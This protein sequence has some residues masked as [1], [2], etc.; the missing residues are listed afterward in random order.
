MASK[1]KTAWMTAQGKLYDLGWSL[2]QYGEGVR[3]YRR[4]KL[5]GGHDY[6]VLVTGEGATGEATEGRLT[7]VPETV[8]PAPL[9][10]WCADL[11]EALAIPVAS[12]AEPEQMAEEAP[13]KPARKPR[14]VKV[15]PVV[16]VSDDDLTGRDEGV[17]A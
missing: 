1:A 17:A 14:K 15:K 6:R 10:Q 12:V 5:G 11:P 16:T 4:P 3:E 2:S 8:P 7:A 13:V 9:A